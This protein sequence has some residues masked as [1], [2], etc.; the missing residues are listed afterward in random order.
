MI[1]K[2]H[3][4]HLQTSAASLLV[5]CSPHRTCSADELTND[6]RRKSA[7]VLERV[8]HLQNLNHNQRQPYERREDLTSSQFKLNLADEDIGHGLQLHAARWSNEKIDSG[9]DHDLERS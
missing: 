8:E 7:A 9:T 3:A 4:V 2:V 1:K 6:V 5:T